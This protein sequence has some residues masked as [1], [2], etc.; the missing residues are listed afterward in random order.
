MHPDASWLSCL[1]QENNGI[2]ENWGEKNLLFHLNVGYS[3]NAKGKVKT[4][5]EEGLAL[6][7]LIVTF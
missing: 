2:S 1:G 3:C 4:L 7:Y 5:V 6:L